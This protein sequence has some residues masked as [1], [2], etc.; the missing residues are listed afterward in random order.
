MKIEFLEEEDSK[1]GDR[2]RKL[3]ESS[4]VLKLN[5]ARYHGGI[6]KARPFRQC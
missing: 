2:H 5:P 1:C 3:K 4:K 6:L